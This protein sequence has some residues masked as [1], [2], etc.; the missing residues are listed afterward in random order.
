MDKLIIILILMVSGIVRGQGNFYDGMNKGMELWKTGQT[1]EASAIFERIAA[2][3]KES[4]LPN[5]YV[6]MVNTTSAFKEKDFNQLNKYL[7]RAQSALDKELAK[8]PNNAELLVLQAMV[9]TAWIAYDPMSYG[10][11]LSGK[12]SQL[13]ARAEQLSP[14]NPR[15]VL[16]K[17]QFEMGSAQFFG[18]DLSPICTKLERSID[19]FDNFSPES[20]FHPN[21]GKNQALESLSNCK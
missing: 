13:Y 20:S 11:S 5:Y 7:T 12:V 15:V 3:E 19:L 9:H 2:A 6:A 10:A 1:E 18:T 8:H 16:G 21:W 4:W 14:E 17:A